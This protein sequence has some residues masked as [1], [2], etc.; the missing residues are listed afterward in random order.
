MEGRTR[1]SSIVFGGITLGSNARKPANAY[2]HGGLREALIEAAFAQVDRA[3]HESVSIAALA[4]TLGVSQPAYHRHFG[5]K[6]A[7]LAAVAVRGF[8]LFSCILRDAVAHR[9]AAE[10]LRANAR[11]YVAFGRDRPGLYQLMFGSPLL[12]KAAPDS[13]ITVAAREC[14]DLLLEA[15]RGSTCRGESVRDAVGIWASL[16]GIVQLERFHLL[17]GLGTRDVPIDSIVD[18]I[19]A[20]HFGTG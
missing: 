15:L 9:P 12:S 7:L 18:D 8:R 14:F 17:D 19:I 6:D 5:D 1:L 11:A 16:H 4:R 3:G 20:R 2:H 13:E 10:Q